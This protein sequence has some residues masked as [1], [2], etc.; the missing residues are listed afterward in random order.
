[1]T[2]GPEGTPQ[3]RPRLVA[4]D[5]DGTLLR[6][7]GSVSTYTS[8]VLAAL[9]A[10]GVPVVFVTARHLS[11]AEELFEHVGSHG[12]AILSNGGLVW[13]VGLSQVHL[14]RLVPATTAREVWRLLRE[15]VPGSLFAVETVD[16]IGLEPGF[17]EP[18][19]IPPGAW[20]APGAELTSA[21]LVKLMALH[22]GIDP[23]D[24]W[25]T[26][27]QVVGHLVTI[28]CSSSAALL[29][30]SGLG[31]TKASTLEMLARDLGVAAEDVVAFGDMP[32]DLPM[33]GWAGLS[34]AM[35]SGHPSVVAAARRVARGNNDDGVAHALA[36]LFG[37]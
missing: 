20:L 35:A 9:E 37:L 7:D 22:R 15:A 36:E 17:V 25:D 24:Y 21:P 23:Q 5:L 1:M 13:D 14:K 18:S 10:R 6:S 26:A 34:Y 4:T 27:E 11:E 29:D 19:W 31:V 32:N 3:A 33:L 12:L 28:T 8:E 16:G 2:A 30:M